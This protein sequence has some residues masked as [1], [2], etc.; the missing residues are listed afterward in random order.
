MSTS[1]C[2]WGAPQGAQAGNCLPIVGGLDNAR[3]AGTHTARPLFEG[4]REGLEDQ[5]PWLLGLQSLARQ[6]LP[7]T[8]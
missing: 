8:S 2:R 4:E 5:P 6:L 1:P 3:D 7:S